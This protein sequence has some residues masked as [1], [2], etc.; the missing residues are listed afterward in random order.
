LLSISR[1]LCSGVVSSERDEYL[2]CW[3]QEPIDVTSLARG[4]RKC[5][6]VIGLDMTR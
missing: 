5:S 3:E 1:K 2:A 4:R 6:V